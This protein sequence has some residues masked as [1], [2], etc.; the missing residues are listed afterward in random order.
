[1]GFIDIAGTVLVV[2]LLVTVLFVVML[3]IV[4]R[5]GVGLTPEFKAT[6]VF[7]WQGSDETVRLELDQFTRAPG[8]YGVWWDDRAGHARLGDIVAIDGQAKAVDRKFIERS[9]SAPASRVE[10]TGQVFAKPDDLG[11]WWSE[12]EIEAALGP[13]PAWHFLGVGHDWVI[14]V[15]GIR[16]SRLSPLRGVPAFAE[17]GYHSLVVSYRGDGDGPAAPGGASTLGLTEWLDVES[18]IDYALAHGAGRIFLMGWSM[19]GG[20]ALLASERA[21]NREALSGVVLVAPA[22]NWREIILFGARSRR[23]G[24]ARSC[25]HRWPRQHPLEQTPGRSQSNRLRDARLDEE[26][27]SRQPPDPCHP[28]AR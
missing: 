8:E 22:T 12:V 24:L 4:G 13:A 20:I 9:G 10:W 23:A 15:H 17:L 11:L 3:R 27:R 7:D 18:A 26:P 14:H 16:V 5:K 1:M 28:L 2:L 19:G 21:H 6:R 25:R